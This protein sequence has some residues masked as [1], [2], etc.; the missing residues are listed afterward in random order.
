MYEEYLNAYKHHS[1]IYGADTAIFYQVGKFYEFY[2]WISPESGNTHTSV[3]RFTDILGVRVTIRKGG[4]PADT[5]GLFAG[6]PEQSLHKYATLLTRLGWVVVVYEQVKDAKGA[7]KS[8]DVSRI[9]TPGTHVE[10]ATDSAAYIGGVWLQAAAWGSQEPLKFATMA[11]DLTTGK[12]LTYEGQASGKASSWI[13]DDIFH[14][15][16]VYLPKECIVWWRGDEIDTPT[17]EFLQR[18]FG[19]PGIRIQILPGNSA[20]QGGFEIPTVREEFLQ[21][22]LS[23]KSLLPTN[24]ALQLNKRL[25]TERLL[26]SV[27]QRIKEQYPSGFNYIPQPQQWIPA[28]HLSLGNQALFQLN[29]VAPQMENSVLGLFQ[30]THTV[31]GRR[32]M[33]NRILYPKADPRE[34]ERRYQEIQS[35][36]DMDFGIK[37]K[38]HTNLRQIEDLPR[39]HKRLSEGEITASEILLLD[40]S[41]I[42]AKRLGPLLEGGALAK[43]ASWSL[44]DIRA[45]FDS[46]FS[47]EKAAVASEDA[48]CFA[49]GCAPEVEGIEQGIQGLFGSL[50]TCVER[51][52][53]WAGCPA[54]SL[55]LEFREVLGPTITGTKATMTLLFKAIQDTAIL[56]AAS[57]VP[58]PGL[59]I[60]QKKSSSQLEV[61]FLETTFQQILRKRLELQKAVRHALPKLCA[62]IADVALPA[63]DALEEWI[64]VIDVTN[65]LATVAVER[66]LVRPEIQEGPT[67]STESF[68][69]IEGLRHPLI[70][71]TKTRVEYVKHAVSLGSATADA[72][73]WL[74]YGMNASGKSSL[75]KAV[76]IAL[77]LAQA[78]CFVPA[79]SFRFHPFQTL[80]T[81]ILN[82][83]N[84]WAGLS[85]FAVE[86]TELREILQNAGP[87]SLVLGDEVCSG[88]ESVSATAIVAA[89]LTHL[90]GR[91]AKFIFATHLHGL[92]DIP[93]LSQLSSLSVWHLKV[94]YDPVTDRLIYERT[95]APGPGSSL[96]GL[97]VARAM[98][99]PEEV[100]TLAHSL[101]RELL[102]TRS[103]LEASGS[104]WNPDIR[105]RACEV[106][107]S[108]I[109][110]DLEVHHIRPRAEANEHGVFND[111]SQQNHVRNLILV[112]SSCHDKSHTGALSIA[113]MV[114]TS[115]G[116]VRMS[117]ESSVV[118]S[119]SHRRS[120][121]TDEQT[122]LIQE[123]LR[124]H[125]NVP[126]KRAVF[127]LGEQGITIS[128]V[129]L[130]RFRSF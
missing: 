3:K 78:G 16:Q 26:C 60:Q 75:M 5:D 73:G 55:R 71:A 21:R 37:E 62:T 112:C 111:G 108:A 63:W 119:E 76:G 113:P 28:N 10:A 45:P 127:D 74:V 69:S 19:L 102:G 90:H 51:L 110:R 47:I 42:C 58:Y 98:N 40:K 67:G 116:P 31:F 101:R 29:M 8:R 114:L 50:R 61:P 1:S 107:G 39:L 57:V 117:T 33:R 11:L 43:G 70:E 48:F 121:W 125:P 130:R 17:P 41:Y 109:V 53:V 59:Q 84:L 13:A 6:V 106:C 86:M 22:V 87:A 34:L 80:F 96:Y 128:A 46:V 56:G 24:R 64:A 104:A 88:T 85:S 77:I 35:L 126:P 93:S 4:G 23:V 124:G 81:R 129:S 15:F 118:S 2:D 54:D 9:L 122:Q 99:L 30:K 82:T 92:L 94:R 65:T 66:G 100:L 7:V 20:D 120:K 25:C 44:E 72:R 95:L 89:T 52:R 49:D 36:I 83:D 32:A 123:Y 91:G 68:V 115:D 105:R 12:S 103:E 14:F 27:L 97:E 18:Q 38:L 79:T